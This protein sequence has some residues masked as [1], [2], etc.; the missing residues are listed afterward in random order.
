MLVFKAFSRVL[1]TL[2]EKGMKLE[3]GSSVDSD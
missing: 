3:S 1:E 2:D